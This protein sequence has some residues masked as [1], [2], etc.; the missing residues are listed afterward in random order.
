MSYEFV[1]KDKGTINQGWWLKISTHKELI[2]YI[3]TVDSNRMIKGWENA[4]NCR[5]FNS[6][7]DIKEGG[8]LKPHATPLGYYIGLYS[9]NREISSIQ[10]V[11]EIQDQKYKAMLIQILK[12][13]NIYINRQGGWHF[14]KNDYS[15][16]CHRDKIIFPDFRVNQIK[17]EKFPGGDHFYAYIDDMQVRDGDILKWNTYE[18]AYEYAKKICNKL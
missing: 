2:E 14:G 11:V 17:V 3:N 13:N 10:A 16:W 4:T 15:D 7:N 8:P 5:E 1:L 6:I 12:G 18:E 9:S